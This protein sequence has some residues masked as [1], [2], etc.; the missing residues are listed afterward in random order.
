M[1]IHTHTYKSTFFLIL[2]DTGTTT[3]QLVSDGYVIVHWLFECESL[4]RPI[5]LDF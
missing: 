3:Y 4:Y 2:Q 1:Y 5:Y